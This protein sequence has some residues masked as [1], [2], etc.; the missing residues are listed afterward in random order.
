MVGRKSLLSAPQVG[1]T[2]GERLSCPENKSHSSSNSVAR[3]V[4][5]ALGV[6]T[7]AV[8]VLVMRIG[9]SQTFNANSDFCSFVQ[10]PKFLKA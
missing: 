10:G 2:V 5:V 8:S 6:G 3:E 7:V 4:P 9:T 1:V